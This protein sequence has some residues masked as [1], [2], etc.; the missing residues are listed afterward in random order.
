MKTNSVECVVGAYSV[1]CMFGKEFTLVADN[2]HLERNFR[3]QKNGELLSV[4]LEFDANTSTKVG[5]V[6]FAHREDANDALQAFSKKGGINVAFF[7]GP[8]K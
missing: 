4:T 7:C 3:F 2:S 5:F 6:E 1:S 8:N